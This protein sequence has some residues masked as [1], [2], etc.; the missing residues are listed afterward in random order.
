MLFVTLPLSSTG[1]SNS[2]DHDNDCF[3]VMHFVHYNVYL[4]SFHVGKFWTAVLPLELY[5]VNICDDCAIARC[6]IYVRGVNLVTIY[7]CLW[8]M[9]NLGQFI[10]VFFR[11]GLEG[12]LKEIEER[13]MDR[14][15]ESHATIPGT[16]F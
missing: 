13:R 14:K 8:D 6:K 2:K 12:T 5:F 16:K 15:G 1:N 10:H 9:C 7:T 11:R 4:S 3:I